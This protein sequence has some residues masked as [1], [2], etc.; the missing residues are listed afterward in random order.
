M[1][2]RYRRRRFDSVPSLQPEWRPLCGC[3]HRTLPVRSRRI[4]DNPSLWTSRIEEAS[5]GNLL[6]ITSKGF[7][8]WD[9]ARII[10]HPDLPARLGVAY[11]EIFHVYE[12]HAGVIWY[13]TTAGLARQVGGLIERIEPDDHDVVFRVTKT[14]RV[15]SGSPNP[16]ICIASAPP[17]GS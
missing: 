3:N 8:E 6:V 12:D 13:C 1:S 14:R 5:N 7:V 11:N 10:P 2:S 15:L 9:G 16:L 17:A 4:C